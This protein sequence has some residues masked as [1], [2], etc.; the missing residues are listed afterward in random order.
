M[1]STKL[2]GIYSNG[3][4]LQRNKE[5]IIEGE[6]SAASEVRVTLADRTVAAHVE[7]GFLEKTASVRNARQI[8]GK[9]KPQKSFRV[10]LP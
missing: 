7:N 6:E 1:S 10:H 2:L 9:K 3:M 4:V 8:Y 5:I